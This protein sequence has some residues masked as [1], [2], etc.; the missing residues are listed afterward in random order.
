[1]NAA[2]TALLDSGKSIARIAADLGF[3]DPF[4]FSKAF[5]TV[6]GMNPRQYRTELQRGMWRTRV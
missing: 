2:K 3:E 1:M 6:T 4:H 5:K